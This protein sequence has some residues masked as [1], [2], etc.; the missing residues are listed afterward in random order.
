MIRRISF[1]VFSKEKCRRE[2]TI[3]QPI[4]FINKDIRYSNAKNDLDV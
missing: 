3:I 1:S 2:P 4:T